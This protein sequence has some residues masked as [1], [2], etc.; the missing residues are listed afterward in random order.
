MITKTDCFLVSIQA[1]SL[2]DLITVTG[3]VR[4]ALIGYTATDAAGG[5]EIVDQAAAWHNDIELYEGALEVEITHLALAS[6]AAPAVYIYPVQE[7]ADQNDALTCAVQVV[8]LRFVVLLVAQVAAGGVS[9]TINPLRN[10][11]FGEIYG[12]KAVPGKNYPTEFVQGN[13]AGLEG[14]VVLWRDVFSIATQINS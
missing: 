12:L 3:S 4:A 14:Q 7:L 13:V 10:E 1:Q 8:D 6:Q 5:I 11:Y 9:A 2:G